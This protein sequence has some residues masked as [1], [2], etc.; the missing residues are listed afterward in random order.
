MSH[1][2][3]CG[4][5]RRNFG[6]MLRAVGSRSGRALI[7]STSKGFAAAVFAQSGRAES[8]GCVA[9]LEAAASRSRFCTTAAAPAFGSDTARRASLLP[10]VPLS[11]ITARHE[12]VHPPQLQ[13]R[14]FAR[15]PF[16]LPSGEMPKK[17][18]PKPLSNNDD[19]FAHVHDDN[20]RTPHDS[21][22]STQSTRPGQ[23][24]HSPH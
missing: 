11:A 6:T 23:P 5:F 21:E 20:K 18:P 24:S 4:A 2:T 1:S 3:T 17:P 16:K 19:D 12:A 14:G 15:L 9:G 7:A 10:L 13:T 22:C 8:A